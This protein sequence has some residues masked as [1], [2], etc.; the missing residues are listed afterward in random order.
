MSRR[1]TK[2]TDGNGF[3]QKLGWTVLLGLVFSAGLITGQRLIED[4]SETPLV[5]V[6]AHRQAPTGDE[7]PDTQK[8]EKDDQE[9]IFSFYDQLSKGEDSK[10]PSPKKKES[11]GE[12]E[13]ER[14]QPDEKPAESEDEPENSDEQSDRADAPPEDTGEKTPESEEKPAESDSNKYTLQ[15]SAHSSLE[16][17]RG[18]MRRLRKMGLDPH[19]VSAQIPEK[20]K[21]YRV[22]IGKFGSM[23]EARHFQSELKRKRHVET[24]VSPL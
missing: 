23:K 5:S 9:P 1:R 7:T 4:R 14:K 22:R 18:R 16:K 15:V 24:F 17:A 11:A 2:Q 8:A 20:G 12:S 13:R 6:S 3:F 21:Y 10:A 19:V